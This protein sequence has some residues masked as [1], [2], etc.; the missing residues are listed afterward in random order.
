MLMIM[1]IWI[2]CG[3]VAVMVA[4]SRGQKEILMLLSCIV[5]GPIGIVLAAKKKKLKMSCP[6]CDDLVDVDKNAC[7]L[8]GLA[9]E[10][11]DRTGE[12]IVSKQCIVCKE[13]DVHDAY[14]ENGSWGKWC[15]HCKMSIK[16]MRKRSS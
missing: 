14:I 16:R 6:Y 1:T 8:C 11:K 5:L 7:S 15:P 2:F 3:V 12:S 13:N 9:L 4:T 10:E